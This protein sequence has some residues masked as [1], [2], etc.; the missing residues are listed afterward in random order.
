M[1]F[2]RVGEAETKYCGM[3]S[4]TYR[5]YATKDEMTGTTDS[6]SGQGPEEDTDDKGY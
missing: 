1:T 6:S 2:E 3:C 4:F 5:V